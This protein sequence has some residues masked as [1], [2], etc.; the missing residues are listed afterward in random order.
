MRVVTITRF[1]QASA[2]HLYRDYRR[3]K[4]DVFVA[5]QGWPLA[6]VDGCDECA[7]DEYDADSLFVMACC[8]AEAIGVVRGTIGND[9]IP[10]RQLFKDHLG[11]TPIG[12]LRPGHIAMVTALAVRQQFRNAPVLLNEDA[13]PSTAARVITS[14]IL[15]WL[16]ERG[17][18]LT[19]CSATPMAAARLF[20]GLGFTV[21]DPLQSYGPH[22]RPILNMACLSTQGRMEMNGACIQAY[23]IGRHD[24]A[25]SGKPFVEYL[26]HAVDVR[27]RRRLRGTNPRHPR[28]PRLP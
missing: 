25:T 1:S 3:I 18:V 27:E 8:G 23:L 2:S 19:L 21:L 9:Q 16:G 26:Q 14:D 15:N 28:H 12:Q 7:P 17:V 22:D 10:H 13:A 24:A 11:D 20:S 6:T 4:Y 5:E